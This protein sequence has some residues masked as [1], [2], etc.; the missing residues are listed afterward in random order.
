MSK[1]SYRDTKKLLKFKTAGPPSSFL[2]DGRLVKKPIELA[3]MQMNY[4]TLKINKLMERLS[5]QPDP[6]I[7]SL[8][9]LRTALQRWKNRD[10]VP[11]FKFKEVSTLETV[12]LIGK[13]GNTT[14]CGQDSIDAHSLKL[15]A[16]SLTLPLKHIINTYLKRIQICKCLEDFKDSTNS[17]K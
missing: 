3:T 2:L 17:E 6:P 9:Y 8:S 13:L 7:N 14:A 10:K 11:E 12:Q 4:F 15:V 1:T 16:D 5:L